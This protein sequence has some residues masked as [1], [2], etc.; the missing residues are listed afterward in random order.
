VGTQK[1]GL[2]SDPRFDSEEDRPLTDEEL[3][4]KW[5][6][7]LWF[8]RVFHGYRI[9]L[10]LAFVLSLISFV[11]DWAG[12][13][14]K[15]ESMGDPRPLSEIWWHFPLMFAALSIFFFLLAKH[16]RDEDPGG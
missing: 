11:G 16:G 2:G 4:R 3:V 15:Y 14:G 5:R 1:L 10:L 9:V 13:R 7:F 6:Y 8:D 12:Y